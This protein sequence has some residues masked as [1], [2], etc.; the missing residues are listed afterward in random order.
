MNTIN[1]TS[2]KID[3]H[4]DCF[5]KENHPFGYDLVG[6]SCW[7]R[8]GRNSFLYSAGSH[9]FSLPCFCALGYQTFPG[10]PRYEAYR[11]NHESSAWLVGQDPLFEKILL[12]ETCSN[13]CREGPKRNRLFMTGSQSPY[14]VHVATR[15]AHSTWNLICITFIYPSNE[16]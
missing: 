14:S 13:L 9:S 5:H 7:L 8:A 6:Y 3:W 11:K 12:L 10:C 1:Q 15:G 16:N 2:L 4:S